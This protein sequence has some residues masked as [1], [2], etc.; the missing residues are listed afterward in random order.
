MDQIWPVAEVLWTLLKV[1]FK[2][3]YLCQLVI[4]I[5]TQLIKTINIYFF[6]M[7]L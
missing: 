1:Y 5:K 7:N 3:L 4:A 2:F 6:L